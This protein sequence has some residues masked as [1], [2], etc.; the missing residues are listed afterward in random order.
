MK[1]ET[2]VNERCPCGSGKKFKK[3]CALKDWGIKIGTEDQKLWETV[4]K[5]CQIE[6]E[7]QEKNLKVQKALLEL[8]E[9]KIKEEIANI[10]KV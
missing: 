2:G 3:C 5:Q 10:E 8:A 9:N 1:K 7:T 6:I 4:K